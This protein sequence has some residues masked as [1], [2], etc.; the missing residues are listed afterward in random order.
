MSEALV[1]PRTSF[2]DSA[3]SSVVISSR[4]SFGLYP[5]SFWRYEVACFRRFWTC[6]G[7]AAG[8]KVSI[9]GVITLEAGPRQGLQ[10]THHARCCKQ[11]FDRLPP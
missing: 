3:I 1:A 11:C 6:K 4:V 8:F 5:S 7:R 10:A 2:R 9:Q